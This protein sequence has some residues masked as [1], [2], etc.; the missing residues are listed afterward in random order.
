MKLS[1]SLPDED[2][3]MLDEYAQTHHLPSRSAALHRAVQ[4]LGQTDLEN[5]YAAAWAE[6]EGSGAEAEW[7]S[8]VGDGVSDQSS[9]R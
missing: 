8:T 3:A 6:W 4:M 9:S 2:V 5:D 7:E 1:V